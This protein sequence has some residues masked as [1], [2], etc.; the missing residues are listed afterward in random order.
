VVQ[1]RRE[2]VFMTR[3]EV[4]ELMA[5]TQRRDEERC[6]VIVPSTTHDADISPFVKAVASSR[7]TK[8]D[9]TSPNKTLSATQTFANAKVKEEQR[10]DGDK[11]DDNAR[12]PNGGGPKKPPGG[13]GDD[14]DHGGAQ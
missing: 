10:S 8:R 14:G 11:G 5:T 3:K 12:R 1:D 13:G 4:L 2:E 7:E 6:A 9:D